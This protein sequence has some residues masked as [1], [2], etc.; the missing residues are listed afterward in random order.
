MN[1]DYN[2]IPIF[3]KSNYISRNKLEMDIKHIDDYNHA[4]NFL[5]RYSK[6]EGTFNSYRREI[7]K[8]LQWCW[9]I[10]NKTLNKIE[11]NDIYE[12]IKFCKS[13]PKNW[14][15]FKK[16]RRFN[17]INNQ[18]IPNKQ[19]KPFLITVEKSQYEHYTKLTNEKYKIKNSALRENILI[20]RSFYNYLNSYKYAIGNPLL[21]ID[22]SKYNYQLKDDKIKSN[23]V[24][25]AQWQAILDSYNDLVSINSHYYE[26]AYFI[27]KLLYHTKIKPSDLCSKN[28]YIPV[29]GQFIKDSSDTWYFNTPSKKLRINDEAL[30]ALKQW[31]KY[32]KLTPLPL[33][34]E[35]TPLLQSLRGQKAI[36]S[37]THIRRIIQNIYDFAAIKLTKNGNHFE[38]LSL[39]KAIITD[40]TS[41][42]Y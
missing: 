38:G 5:I 10:K 23:G 4:K 33:P 25:N 13:P 21:S 7:E 40:L 42:V 11:N 9:F 37:I 12:Y 41:K 19:W 17:Q 8:F 2:P 6:S 39:K 14:I 3:D 34:D 22:I 26:R 36:S 16:V 27:I 32:L 31:R 35:K 15:G 30:K 18:R 28:Q 20:L 1:N 29:M 24:S